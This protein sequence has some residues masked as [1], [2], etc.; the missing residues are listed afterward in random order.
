[1]AL[2]APA[3]RVDLLNI[4]VASD[5]TRNVQCPVNRTPWLNAFASLSS[6]IQPEDR[7]G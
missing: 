2:L 6:A 4:Y 3:R 5:P 7:Q 1:M